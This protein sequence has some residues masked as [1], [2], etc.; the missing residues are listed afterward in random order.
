[1]PLRYIHRSMETAL[2][3][4]ARQFPVVVLTGPRQSGKT[5]ILKKLFGKS[6]RY[7]SLEPPDVQASAVKDPRGFLAAFEPPVIFDEIQY[8]PNLLPYIKEMV[9]AR[10]SLRGRFLLTGS[11]NLLL[12]E[13]ITESLAGRAAI[14]KLLPLSF[15]ESRGNRNTSFRWE[16]GYR[17]PVSNPGNLWD[18]ILRGFYP[19]LTANPRADIGL[20]H[21]SY[22]QTYLERDVRNLRQVGN[23]TQFQDFLKMLAARNAQLLNI[24]DLSRDLGVAVNT[25]K[26]W[27]S[28]LEATY[29]VFILRPYHANIGKRLVKM[30]KIYFCDTGMLCHLTGLKHASHAA[31]GP[32]AGSLFETI[33]FTELLKGHLH[34]GIEPRIYFWRTSAGAEVDFIVEFG[35]KLMPIEVKLTSTPNPELARNI[36]LFKKDFAAICPGGLL[37]H[38]G[39]HE[40]P[41]GDGVIAVPFNNM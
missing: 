38:Q 4:A 16:T 14:L 35:G 41:L 9:D 36:R 1:M 15:R 24:T 19:E 10:R 3:K 32:M 8:A 18:D 40:L 13:K 29:Q 26:A 27:L 34:R 23:L 28:V 33:V 39:R 7:V 11:Q 30:P 12:A 6:A 31:S 5:T 20:F 2:K 22:I 25:I 17:K 37:V 21:S